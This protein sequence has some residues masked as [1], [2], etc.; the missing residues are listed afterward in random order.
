[1][2]RTYMGANWTAD[3]MAGDAPWAICDVEQKVG[4]EIEFG[5]D[6][7]G[8]MDNPQ[9]HFPTSELQ[10]AVGNRLVMTNAEVVPV[11]APAVDAFYLP[12]VQ[13]SSC[14]A[15]PTGPA[16]LRT[17]SGSN[18]AP[19]EWLLHE[20]RLRLIDNDV[21]EPSS[22]VI[23]GVEQCVVVPRTFLN[24][25]S[26]KVGLQRC[27]SRMYPS[28][29]VQLD[30]DTIK[31]FYEH[32]GRHVHYVTGLRLDGEDPPCDDTTSRWRRVGAGDQCP[33]AAQPSEGSSAAID[34]GTHDWLSELILEADDDADVIDIRSKDDECTAASKGVQI[35]VTDNSTGTGVVTCWQHVHH[36]ELSV[37]DF[38]AW[39]TLHQ[40]NDE[41]FNGNRPNPIAKFA[42]SG[43]ASLTYPSWH[44]M[45][46]WRGHESKHTY[47]GRRNQNVD[48]A[49][50]PRELVN[51]ALGTAIGSGA[52]TGSNQAPLQEFCGSPGEVANEPA[53]GMRYVMGIAGNNDINNQEEDQYVRGRRGSQSKSTA[54]LNTVMDA[55]DQLR[56]RVAWALAQ[57]FVVSQEGISRQNE[58]EIFLTYYDIFVRN[59]FGSYRDIVKEVSYSPAMARMLTFLE[60][61]SLHYSKYIWP[62]KELY[63]DENYAREIM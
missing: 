29:T 3:S 42:M 21:S 7:M 59:A 58:M 33:Q 10:A 16:F 8:R 13:G 56:Q 62:R 47:I 37:Y 45:S 63:P 4:G 44:M 1:M 24:E 50:L 30:D 46:R 60:T 6:C 52:S 12:A 9:V 61:R 57:I 23:R 2:P 22:D 20:S 31:A 27:A 38:T 11:A 40:G 43:S 14:D 28:R 17:S 51:D 48:F 55:P 36:N 32:V 34:Q 54:W 18:G 19:S 26:C 41:A 5:T 25:H 53:E 15:P 35:L 49:D 39:T